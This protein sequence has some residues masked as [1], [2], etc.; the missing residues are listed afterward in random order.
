MDYSVISHDDIKKFDAAQL[1]QAREEIG[2]EL[3]KIRMDVYSPGSVHMGRKRKLK[4]AL[5]RVN[6]VDTIRVKEESSKGGA[7]RE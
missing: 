7:D 4:R 2:S 3:T 5:A 1:K 6:T